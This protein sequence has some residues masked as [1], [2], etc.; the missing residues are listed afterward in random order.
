LNRVALEGILRSP[1]NLQRRF[2]RPF[3]LYLLPSTGR[4]VSIGFYVI[5]FG[6]LCLP[7][8]LRSLKLYFESQPGHSSRTATSLWPFFEAAFLTYLF[9]IITLSV[10]L[11][12]SRLDLPPFTQL[13]TTELLHSIFLSLSAVS[14][15]PLFLRLCKSPPEL[16]TQSTTVLINSVSFSVG[17]LRT[18]CLSES[19]CLPINLPFLLVHFT[20]T[21]TTTTTGKMDIVDEVEAMFEEDDKLF[22]SWVK[23][24]SVGSVANPPCPAIPTSLTTEHDGFYINT[25][26]LKPVKEAN[27]RAKVVEKSEFGK[28]QNSQKLKRK[29]N[30]IDDDDDDFNKAD[31]SPAPIKVPRKEKEN[32]VSIKQS[33][34]AAAASSS[35]LQYDHR[36]K[37][38]VP[39]VSVLGQTQNAPQQ[40]KKNKR[41][42]LR[43]M[44]RQSVVPSAMG[45]QQGKMGKGDLSSFTPTSLPNATITST[46]YSSK[47][48]SSS[49]VGPVT[50]ATVISSI[51]Q[52]TIGGNAEST[53]GVGTSNSNNPSPQQLKSDLISC[54]VPIEIVQ[55]VPLSKPLSSDRLGYDWD[56]FILRVYGTFINLD[57]EDIENAV[58][59]MAEFLG[60]SSG[61]LDNYMGTI[62]RNIFHK[63]TLE[64]EEAEENAKKS[65][66]ETVVIPPVPV[67]L[68]H[69][70]RTRYV[71]DP[72]RKWACDYQSCDKRFHNS[73][74][75][76]NHKRT[77]TGEKPFKCEAAGCQWAFAQKSALTLHFKRRH[78]EQ[79][80]E[81]TVATSSVPGVLK[82]VRG[83]KY[84][85]D[86]TRKWACDHQGCDKKFRDPSGLV[87]HK[88]THTGE[89]PFK[90]EAAGCQW[91][92]AQK[93]AL[94]LHFKRRHREQ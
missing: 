34:S 64:A 78:G 45:K 41:Q 44:G 89:K 21:T 69:V 92:F 68:K 94:T 76:E 37:S 24:R 55:T 22:P 28:V 66:E 1:N 82:Q 6:L 51:Q 38:S 91:A 10:P 73:Y 57:I 67:M 81:E 60:F 79:Q 3:Y 85:D 74:D 93:S 15:L 83:S 18:V 19:I 90:C 84:I 56:V 12:L 53:S 46:L 54:K 62:D 36:P 50:T 63:M 26:E 48:P 2:H 52:M 42:Q 7:L 39:A 23:K 86:P 71:H 31:P 58:E 9:G 14:L 59:T 72:T 27:G 77:H 43:K 5:A 70:R 33:L 88:R 80:K 20:T 35:S 16:A 17:T 47:S 75:L 4:Y 87:N 25:G 13:A 8:C 40:P 11:L 61:G 32:M 30:R 29:R 49:A 65:K